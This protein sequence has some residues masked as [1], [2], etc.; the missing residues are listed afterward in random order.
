MSSNIRVQRIC[1]QCGKEFEART[2]VTRTC[3]DTCAKRLYKAKQKEAKV[4]AS[5]KET[6]QIK[7]QPVEAVKSKEYLTIKDTAILLN[8][9]RQT[10]YNL[11]EK[12]T[13]RAVKL[14]ER[15]TLIKR[16]DIDTLFNPSQ[17]A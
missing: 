13:L 9:S 14:S 2:T 5:N 4:E 11:I 3:S 1:Q 7:A 15:K 10:I 16:T 6:L 8:S 12:G 17:T